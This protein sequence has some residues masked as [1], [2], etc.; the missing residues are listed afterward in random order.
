VWIAT[1][2][3][4]AQWWE[5]KAQNRAQF[6]REGDHFRVDVQACRDSVI[7]VRE[8]GNERAFEPR[9]FTVD[10]TARPCVS[11]APGTSREAIT[12]LT[13]L[14]Y[15]VETGERSDGYAVHLG[16]VENAGYATIDACRR[17]IEESK[18]PLVRFGYGRRAAAVRLP[19]PATSTRSPSGTLCSVFA[20]C[21]EAVEFR[22]NPR[23][24][25]VGEDL[26]E[27]W[28]EGIKK[29]AFSMGRA[30]FVDHPV[31]VINVDRSGVIFRNGS[32][33][34][35]VA[36]DPAARQ[37]IG[38]PTPHTFAI[39]DVPG[40]RTFI[41]PALR[42]EV[43][44]FV[45]NLVVYVASPS[46][47]LGSFLRAFALRR[48]WPGARHAMVALIPRRHRRRDRILLAA[49]APDVI[50]VPSYASLLHLKDL[51]L[52]GDL[53]PV[54]VDLA[55]F[56]KPHEGECEQLR[57][58]YNVPAGATVYLHVGH[59]S[60]K[61]NVTSLSRLV[62]EPGAH[63]IVIGSTSTPEDLSLR[64]AL[65]AAGVRVIRELV[66]VEEF[67]RLADAY[68]FPVIDSEGCV[69]IPLSV[70]EALASGLPVIARP[71]GGLRD[72]LAAGADL[73]Y[74]ETED[75]MVAR[76]RALR[77]QPRP[78][79][80]DMDDFSWRAVAERLVERLLQPT[81]EKKP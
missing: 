4:I 59:L 31:R 37:S 73:R 41:Q 60:P 77:A 68:V 50:F 43:A 5:A 49:T 63:V 39:H 69:E 79:T 21:S 56:R 17:V 67:Y 65:E 62:S 12:A 10:S 28:D 35:K 48:A 45:P 3:E 81:K 58:K 70:L 26:V 24:V 2:D 6:V 64:L 34:E 36:K 33:A 75:E 11:V 9:T 61:R 53:L 74:F 27:P 29:F 51:S 16:R 20:V 13:D 1:L 78:E 15:I 25:I 47:T 71:F 55:Q 38:R 19:P 40:T 18:R 57:A 14:G 44:S 22:M 54:G 66:A 32:R 42:H 52:R 72:V 30:L 23:I 76:A 7:L 8:G 80:R 46:D